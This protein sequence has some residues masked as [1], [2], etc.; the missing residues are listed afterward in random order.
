MHSKKNLFDL[1]EKLKDYQ[2]E[3]VKDFQPVVSGGQNQSAVRALSNFKHY[4][5]KYFENDLNRFLNWVEGSITIGPILMHREFLRSGYRHSPNMHHDE[6]MTYA[7][8]LRRNTQD[9]PIATLCIVHG[10]SEH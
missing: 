6:F 3:V 4:D 2:F 5:I 1:S 9:T 10:F 7:T 8:K